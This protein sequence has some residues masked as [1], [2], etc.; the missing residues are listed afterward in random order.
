VFEEVLMKSTPE[1]V[2]TFSWD[3]IAQDVKK[4]A[5]TFSKLLS[6]IASVKRRLR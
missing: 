1:A 3:D 5:P 6:G 2:R 4:H